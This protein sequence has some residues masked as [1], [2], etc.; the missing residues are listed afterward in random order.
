MSRRCSSGKV[1]YPTYDLAQHALYHSWS[2]SRPG[3]KVPLRCYYCNDCGQYHLT[4]QPKK[5]PLDRIVK[6]TLMFLVGGHYARPQLG[7]TP[8]E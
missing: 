7:C 5:N 3:H 8:Q 2:V 4:S 1:G 6:D